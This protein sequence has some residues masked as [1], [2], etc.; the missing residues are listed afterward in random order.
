MRTIIEYAESADPAAHPAPAVS[1][2]AYALAAY[3]SYARCA[4]PGD[5]RP[6]QH[7]GRAAICAAEAARKGCV[8]AIVLEVGRAVCDVAEGLDVNLCWYEWMRPLLRAV[9]GDPGMAKR[10]LAQPAIALDGATAE[11]LIAQFQERSNEL[12]SRSEYAAN[13]LLSRI[14]ELSIG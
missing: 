2:R 3:I 12:A 11:C 4:P 8:S 13:D 9:C 7:L 5:G 1:A 10:Y 14:G 6:A